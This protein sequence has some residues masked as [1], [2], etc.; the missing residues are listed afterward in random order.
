MKLKCE[1]QTVYRTGAG[2]SQSSR[3]SQGL[4]VLSGRMP[5]LLVTAYTPRNKRGLRYQVTSL[6][7]VFT[8][9]AAA[10][11]TSLSFRE[12]A[13]DLLVTG[14]PVHVRAFLAQLSGAA[15]GQDSERPPPAAA[16]ERVQPSQMGRPPTRLTARTSGE[17]VRA[18]PPG[19][20]HLAANGIRLRR[21]E[22]RLLRL[23]QLRSLDLSGNRLTRLPP[24]DRRLPQL[25][26][27]RLSGNQLETLEPLAE[28]P[29]DSQLAYLDVSGNRLAAL[30]DTLAFL[31]KLHFLN[32]AGNQ[33][34]TLPECVTNLA[35]LRVV[36]V[37]NNRL[38]WLPAQLERMELMEVDTH[39][40]AG[41]EP[42]YEPCSD[43][44]P[45]L[46]HLAAG[47]AVRRLGGRLPSAAELPLCLLELLVQCDRC[48][49][50]GRPCFAGEGGCEV[51]LRPGPLR[52]GR[53]SL[54]HPTGRPLP[55][56]EVTCFRCVGRR[57]R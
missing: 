50:C 28:R 26:E 37:S 39:G 16:P 20:Q 45:S 29:A 40:N 53:A 32:A 6:T 51:R 19:L 2:A 11:K 31:T 46:E 42:V 55:L 9:H 7:R 3:K 27:L 12:P 33:L 15:R 5:E 24:I 49:Q 21:V 18:F 4:L 56:R 25:C 10:G 35:R 54:V 36:N 57:A 22:E 23:S 8:R 43:Q 14:D 52:H 48:R 41:V 47:A 1:L 17:Y 38:S 13:H 34:A 30:P 44:P